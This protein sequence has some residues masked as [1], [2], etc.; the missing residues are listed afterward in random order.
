MV[1]GGFALATQ[2]RRGGRGG[3]RGPQRGGDGG[4]VVVLGNESGMQGEAAP[5][6]FV[7]DGEVEDGRFMGEDEM[8]PL[9]QRRALTQ[10]RY[11]GIV[12][13]QEEDEKSLQSGNKT[14][15]H[16]RIG[17]SPDPVGKR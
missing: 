11:Q 5:Q 16:T 4:G 1:V 10:D 13:A 12:D 15:E 2:G 6:F 14:T 3:G 7:D 17:E 8:N 9:R